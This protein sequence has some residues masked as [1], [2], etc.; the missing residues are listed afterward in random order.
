M[1]LSSSVGSLI[2]NASLV[3]K[4]YF[5]REALPLA[6]LGASIMHFFFQLIVLMVA[7]AALRYSVGPALFVLVPAAFVV[8]VLFLAG[9]VLIMAVLNVYFRDVQHLLE[10]GL[11]AWFWLTPVVYPIAFLQANLGH[12]W[13]FS[14]L[15][16][17]TAIVL[18]YQRGIYGKVSAVAAGHRQAVLVAAPI[19]WY[20]RNLGVVAVCSVALLMIGW[21]VF[22][23]LESRLA[24][25]L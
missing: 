24:E 7:V 14:L 12:Y 22:R 13:R 8:E 2:G 20:L 19:W 4:V 15:N 17:M 21:S 9:A 6:S 3:T 10:V 25:E 18:A 1:A 16:P 23:R 5:P 11:L